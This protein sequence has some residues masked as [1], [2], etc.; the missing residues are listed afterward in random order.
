MFDPK[1]IADKAEVVIAGFAVVEKLSLIQSFIKDHYQEM[2]EMWRERSANGF[3][4][5]D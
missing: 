5:G 2:Y 3:Y 1:E 4:N